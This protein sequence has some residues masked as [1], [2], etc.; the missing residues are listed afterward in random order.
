MLFCTLTLRLTDLIDSQGRSC[1]LIRVF[2]RFGAI[3]SSDTHR[4]YV[5]LV[6]QKISSGSKLSKLG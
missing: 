6:Q 1:G 2:N 3:A 4:Q 5:Q